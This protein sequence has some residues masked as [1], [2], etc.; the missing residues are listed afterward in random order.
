MR[1]RLD[2]SALLAHYRQE[3]GGEAVQRL[4]EEEEATL[5]WTI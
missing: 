5:F 3:R 4:F 1:Y 2:T